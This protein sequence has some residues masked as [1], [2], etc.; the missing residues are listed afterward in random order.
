MDYEAKFSEVKQLTN[1]NLRTVQS[2]V[3][4]GELSRRN[5]GSSIDVV[6]GGEA[7]PGQKLLALGVRRPIPCAIGGANGRSC[8][9]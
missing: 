4:R 3:V 7:N 2:G 8:A 5:F 9:V 6:A 1:L